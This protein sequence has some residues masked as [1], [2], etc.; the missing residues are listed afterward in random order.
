MSTRA[1]GASFPTF[2]S[3]LGH[4]ALGNLR[5]LTSHPKSSG[6]D[7]RTWPLTPK[8]TYENV[9][10]SQLL[11]LCDSVKNLGFPPSLPGSS[12]PL[13]LSEAKRQQVDPHLAPHS[14][15]RLVLP[16]ALKRA[17]R[18]YFLSC[19]I[20]LSHPLSW[21]TMALNMGQPLMCLP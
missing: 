1:R 3:V 21:P 16:P 12:G 14:Q 17:L 2:N 5:S 18:F 10:D 15:I 13:P 6:K 7:G 8:I 20:F 4:T 19:S 11:L 9:R